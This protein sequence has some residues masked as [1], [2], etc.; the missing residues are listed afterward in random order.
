MGRNQRVFSILGLPPSTVMRL[1]ESLQQRTL[2][3]GTE[4]GQ[5]MQWYWVFAA[6]LIVASALMHVTGIVRFDTNLH[7]TAWVAAGLVLLNGGWMA[8]DG[9]HA[10][11]VGD[12]VTPK[13]GQFAGTLGPWSK[14]V[15]AV[16]IELGSTLMK[17]VF[18][19]YGLAYL[20]AMGAFLLG[21]TSAWWA[22]IVLAVLE[23]VRGSAG[24]AQGAALT[25][26]R[27]AD[28]DDGV[29]DADCSLREAIEAATS[30]DEVTIP[31]GIYTL[32]LGF[33]LL[34][35]KDLTLSGAAE[36][37]TIIQAATSPG[38][39]D[40]RVFNIAKGNVAAAARVA[41]ASTIP[42]AR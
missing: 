2:T 24:I 40:S 7:W 28:T 21:S 20:T 19:I 41:V 38:V 4:G 35:D 31:A 25:V 23:T 1:R 33:E 22:L 11:I 36:T 6:A 29:C 26:T 10:F 14:I 39:A 42:P 17:S 27:T 37:S 16:G 30:G 3:I 13:S 5:R 15:S 12:Y 34:I 9:G 18:I 32:I 8:F